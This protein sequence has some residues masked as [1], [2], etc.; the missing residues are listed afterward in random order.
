MR[1][2]IPLERIRQQEKIMAEMYDLNLSAGSEPHAKVITFGC[3]QNEADSE[4]LRGM[5]LNMGYA[6]TDDN[7]SADVIVINTCAV[8]EHAEQRVF[9]LLGALTHAKKSNP[10]LVIA[11]CGCMAL[12]SGVADKIRESFRHISLVFSPQELWRFPELLRRVILEKRR[13]FEITP[14][15]GAIAEGLPVHRDKSVKA[16]LPIMY[17]CNNFCSYCVVP[18]TRG[19]ERS[20]DPSDIITEA[21]GLIADG[22][23][24][25]TLLGQ[26]VNSYGRDLDEGVDFSDIIAGIN[27]L[28]GDFLIRFM[29]SHPK[30]AG[31]R[32]FKT[33]ASCGK[34]A[35]HIHLPFQSGC[36]RVLKAMNRKYTRE[37]YLELITMAREYMPDVVITSDVIVGFPGET[38]EEFEET[39]TLIETVRFDALFTFIYS[40]R[41]GTPAANMPDPFTREQKQARFDKLTELQNRISSEK[42]A[43]SIG[44]T[45]R[46]LIDGSENGR[47]TARTNGGRL[48]RLD[49]DE[50]FIGHFRD[51]TITSASTWALE[52]SLADLS[53]EPA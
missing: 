2:E 20:R 30:D 50:D 27:D 15:D 41:G 37:H 29:T 19:R 52:G 36:T 45:Y 34:A 39:L 14:S 47:L 5:L 7:F 22:Y 6:L 24:D 31:E 53:R 32:L 25:I 17:G 3:Q 28:D 10:K 42:H 44:K 9:G 8:R 49:G 18:Y 43:A 16:W 51:V 11:L 38:D 40:K 23:R 4:K 13:V 26:N 33:M 21:R 46:V 12:S 1:H 35:R 48:V